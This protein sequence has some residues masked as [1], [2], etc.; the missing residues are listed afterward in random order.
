MVYPRISS[1]IA[2]RSKPFS[3]ITT[4][5]PRRVAGGPRSI[6]LVLDA[7][8]DALHQQPHRLAGDVDEALHAQD[9][10]RLGRAGEAVDQLPAANRT[11][12]GRR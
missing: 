5:R 11:S 8:A 6:E 7:R 10:V 3:P 9:V 1:E 2:P 4:R 12:A